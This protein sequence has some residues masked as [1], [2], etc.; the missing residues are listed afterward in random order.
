MLSLLGLVPFLLNQQQLHLHRLFHFCFFVPYHF[1]ILQNL[2]SV[3][4]GYFFNFPLL[5]FYSV[6]SLGFALLELL[7]FVE[8]KS[9][10]LFSEGGQLVSVLLCFFHA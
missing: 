7:D 6:E 8:V 5:I 4:K 2:L 3:L 9:F 10:H 1:F